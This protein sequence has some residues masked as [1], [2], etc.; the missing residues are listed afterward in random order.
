ME[1]GLVLRGKK[2]EYFVCGR[3]FNFIVTDD[4]KTNLEGRK[5][6]H[7]ETSLRA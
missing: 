1:N 3:H 7:G 4:S 2:E 5:E 6:L